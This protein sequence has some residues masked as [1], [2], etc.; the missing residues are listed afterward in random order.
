M[1]SVNAAVNIN[2]D[3][4]LQLGEV[5]DA[6]SGFIQSADGKVEDYLS[7]H[8]DP[9]TGDLNVSSGEIIELQKLMADQS[10]AT[11]TG[12]S[13]LKSVKDSILA[14]SRNI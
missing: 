1:P 6:F 5:S 4:A 8:T 13:T 11:Q 12:T 2:S 14:A 9:T 3:D 10:I 7:A